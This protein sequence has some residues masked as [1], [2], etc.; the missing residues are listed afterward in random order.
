M[1]ADLTVAV[2]VA[3]P[4]ELVWRRV[5]DWE[6]QRDWVLGTRVEVTSGDGRT[7]GSTLCATTGY[8][9]AAFADTMDV[10]EFVEGG[11]WRAVV[12]HTGRVVR[13]GGIFEVVELGPGRSR[14]LWT[15]QLDL[16][17]GAL[18]RAGWPLLRPFTRALLGL[19]CRRLA[20]L[21][22]AELA[23]A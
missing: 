21:C 1:S 16:P 17:L 23:G 9:P 10:T 13:G 14:F 3:A 15:E 20:R 11:P 5:S 18:G 22:E 8:G 7:V 2:D 19:S 4:V 12:W 6:G